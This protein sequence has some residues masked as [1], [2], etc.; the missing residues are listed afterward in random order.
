MDSRL[1][2]MILNSIRN[3]VKSVISE[4]FNIN[5]LN[6]DDQ[7]TADYNIFNKEIFNPFE[8]YDKILSNDKH[9]VTD[10]EIEG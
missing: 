7:E 5:D 2:S 8:I 10:D 6:F 3:E 1:Y 4:Q 9:N